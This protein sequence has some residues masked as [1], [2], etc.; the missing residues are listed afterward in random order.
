MATE[1][2]NIQSLIALLNQPDGINKVAEQLAAKGVQIS[3]LTQI[4]EQVIPPQSTFSGNINPP[5]LPASPPVQIP[6]PLPQ[7][8][9]P[10]PTP[11]PQT[12]PEATNTGTGPDAFLQAL[13]ALEVPAAP[14]IP[15]APPSAPLPRGGGAIN[16]QF[17]E[18]LRAILAPQ[19]APQINSLGSLITG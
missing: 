14:A 1:L 11:P 16:P 17:L 10:L 15:E 12:V 6:L 4:V 2:E 3:E 7:N 19:Q 13:L 5:A 18:Q 9:T 8:A